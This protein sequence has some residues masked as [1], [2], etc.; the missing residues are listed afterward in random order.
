MPTWSDILVELQ[1]VHQQG[2]G[3]IPQGWGPFD[4]VRRKYIAQ[5][6]QLTGRNVIV[7]AAK[8]TQGQ[9]QDPESI[10]I[11][12]EDVQGFMEVIH[13]L[14]PTLGLDL[15]LHSPGGSA[16]VADAIVKYLRSRFTDI[17]VFI[18]QAAMSAASMLS[19]AS[20]R[21]VM[22]RHSFMGPVDPQFIFHTENGIQVAP[23]HA[24]MEQF[25]MAQ[26]EC[27]DPSLLPTWIPILRQIGPGLIIQ[28]QLATKL[29]QSLVKEWL[30]DYML[31]G[32]PRAKQKAARIA[33]TLANHAAFMSHG[34][35]I[36]RD[37]LRKLG[38]VVDDLEANQNVQDAVLSV[39]HA[40][41]HSFGATPA[42][43][44][45]E[46]HLNKAFVKVQQVMTM[47][48]PAFI[49]VQPPMMTPQPFP[50]PPTP[51]PQR[52]TQLPPAPPSSGPP[53]PT[54]PTPTPPTAQTP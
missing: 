28:C 42:V 52:P 35:F 33:R 49:P 53:T 22:G 17:R 19:C 44:I 16:E 26:R 12:E 36:G 50:Q 27:K 39:F 37:Q 13:G 21:I 38:L 14:N 51:L 48:M 11:T 47:Q 9:V 24:I 31:K 40:C 2:P 41:T 20:N 15:I 43:K 4:F 5:L 3:T 1:Q 30:A 7:Y 54:P 6:H 23:A 45:I 18:P 32:Q 10:S 46:N 8:W 29:S 25:R 34:R